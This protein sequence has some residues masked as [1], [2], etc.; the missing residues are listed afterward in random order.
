MVSK[1]GAEIATG[2]AE[3]EWTERGERD[4]RI[5]VASVCPKWAARADR[6]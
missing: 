2:D 3:S 6:S 1:R 4:G 5:F